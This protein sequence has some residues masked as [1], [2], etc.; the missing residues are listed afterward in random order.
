MFC[1]R[2]IQFYN[3]L[4][5]QGNLPEGVQIM[6][7]FSGNPHIRQIITQFYSRFFS[8][9]NSRTLILGINPGRFGAGATGIPFTDTKHLNENCG[10]KFT[11]FQTHE[12]S[13][14]F[15]YEMIDTFGSVEEFYNEFFISA[16]CP[17]GFTI[18]NKN[19]KQVNYN[20]YDSKALLFAVYPFIVESLKKQ[21]DFG[22]DKSVCFCLG[23]GKNEAFIRKLND[24]F[25]FFKK[26]IALE[27]PRY[28]MQYKAKAKKQYIAK[29]VE[30]LGCRL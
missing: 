6:N 8:D 5:F 4:H 18:K 10:I 3:Q 22:V 9:N 12:P 26:I 11:E 7:P 23:T 15:I 13:S 2:V 30:A 24:Q 17:L 20:Y 29:Y 21:L 14:V 28:I 25:G 27:H 16:I 19:N 1:D